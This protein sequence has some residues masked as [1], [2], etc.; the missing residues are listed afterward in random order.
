MTVSATSSRI[1]RRT[2]RERTSSRVPSGRRISR[3][4]RGS[5]SR[6][7]LASAPYAMAI[8]SGV[9]ES[10][11]PMAWEAGDWHV[12]SSGLRR[13]PALSPAMGIP[14]RSPNPKSRSISHCSMGVRAWA[15]LATATFDETCT[16]RWSVRTPRVPMSERVRPQ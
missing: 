11:Y 14:V 1:T 4:I 13:M 15:A 7:P 10:S 16:A 5:M 8:C 2:T 9:A 3:T 6:P 12:Q